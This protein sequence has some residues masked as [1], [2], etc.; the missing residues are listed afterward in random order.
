MRRTSPLDCLAGL[1]HPE[2]LS[3]FRKDIDSAW[4]ETALQVTGTA[5]IRKRRLP[6]GQV[7]WLVIGMAL[8]RNRGIAAVANSLDLALPGVNTGATAAR[9]SVSEARKRLGE[10]PVGWLFAHSAE[11]WA[12]SS[13]DRDR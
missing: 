9:S 6:A 7:I 12:G 5:T 2:D 11:Q 4:I 8:F 1:P 3:Q 13:A 10:Q